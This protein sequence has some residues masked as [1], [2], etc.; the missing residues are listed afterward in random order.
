MQRAGL[1]IVTAAAAGLA[2]AGIASSPA[3][4]QGSSLRESQRAVSAQPFG[5]FG[6]GAPPPCADTASRLS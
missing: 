6:A 2:M 5:R 1:A 4:A 3:A